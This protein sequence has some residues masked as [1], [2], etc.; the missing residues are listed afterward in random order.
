MN[1]HSDRSLGE[2]VCLSL[3]VENEAHGW[4][5][6][7]LLMPD[8][9]IGRVWSLSRALTYRAIDTLVAAKLLQPRKGVSGESSR[10]RVVFRSTAAG[11]RVCGDWLATPV[12]HLRDVRTEF[13]LKLVLRQRRDLSS[14][15]LIA[16]QQEQFRE[17]TEG[18]LEAGPDVDV[19]DTWRREH[20][21][22]VSRFLQQAAAGG[23]GQAPQSKTVATQGGLRL[24]ARNQVRA[25][26]QS[27][28]YGEVMASVKVT[29]SA[30]D[31]PQVLT[32]AITR[33]AV[34]DLDIAAGDDVVLIM[35]ATEVLIAKP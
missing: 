5:V 34:N 24:S 31:H 15:A 16:A 6:G 29:V 17:V 22:A 35:K 27:D 32:A 18:L 10:E 2:L 28:T 13:L 26:V 30:T 9:E 23:F 8:G 4:A 12:E 25:T 14:V 33:D 1:D 20:A 3:I 19:V 21:R 11:R 7:S